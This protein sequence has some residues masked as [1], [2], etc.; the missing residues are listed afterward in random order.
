ML[1]PLGVCPAASQETQSLDVRDHSEFT[2]ISQA[3]PKEVL[4]TYRMAVLGPGSVFPYG[5]NGGLCFEGFDY[6]EYNGIL[7][8]DFEKS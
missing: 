6:L 7:G 3:I 8:H 5:M 1:S 2:T 4:S